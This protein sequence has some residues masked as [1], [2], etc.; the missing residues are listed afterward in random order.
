[1]FSP[2]RT[3]VIPAAGLGT[4]FMPAAKAV[5]KEL[6][7]ILDRP[8][9]Q[10]IVEEAVAAGAERIVIVTSAGKE[11]LRRHFEA[12]P[13]LEARLARAGRDGQRAAIAAAGE[14]GRR[15][16][17]VEQPQPK[18]L[19][20]AVLCAAAAVGDEPFLV[21]LGD[22]LIRSAVPCARQLVEAWQQVGGG[23]VLG[24]RPVPMELTPRYGIVAG[25]PVA[26]RLFNLSELV[27]K[28]PLGGAPSNLAISGRYLLSPRVFGELRKIRPGVGGEL[29][30]TDAIRALVGR[31]PV[32]GLVYDGV[33]HD[34]GNPL[35][36]FEAVVAYA[37]ERPEYAARLH[38][39]M[40]HGAGVAVSR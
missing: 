32:H 34:L 2:I 12:D 8:A 40:A 14:L 26:E 4:R 36:Y 20:D 3:A 23:S 19:G 33:R 30:L 39:I 35:D 10:W 7:P 28:P 29:Q 24:L 15:I 27:E 13:G 21:L 1:M 17:W 5:P 16:V 22:A 31:E 37:L 38:R 25:T 18:G 9:L 11:A 6:M